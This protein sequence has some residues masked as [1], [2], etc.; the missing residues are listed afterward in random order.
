MLEYETGGSVKNPEAISDIMVE[1][2]GKKKHKDSQQMS[3]L[4]NQVQMWQR[5]SCPVKEHLHFTV[6]KLSRRG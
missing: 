5:F 4:K 3:C 6:I 2:L 1:I